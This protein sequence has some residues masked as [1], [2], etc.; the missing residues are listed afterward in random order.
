MPILGE[1]KVKMRLI[2]LIAVQISPI[3]WK[4]NLAIANIFEDVPI[5]QSINLDIYP[6]TILRH[7]CKATCTGCLLQ[8]H[9]N[10]KNYGNN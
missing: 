9:H 6:K 10:R 4:S 3:T 5:I 2:W 8:N 7:I 1:N